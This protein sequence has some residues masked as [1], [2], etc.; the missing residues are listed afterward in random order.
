MIIDREAMTEWA[1]T[2]PVLGASC[3]H[4][5]DESSILEIQ[6]P[7]D[8]GAFKRYDGAVLW[9]SCGMAK[10]WHCNLMRVS[11]MFKYVTPF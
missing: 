6:V 10:D 1:E 11:N 3:L 5:F 9:R 7:V 4:A 8:C 2:L